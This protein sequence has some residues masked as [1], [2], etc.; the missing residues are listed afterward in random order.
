MTFTGNPYAR[1]N[2]GCAI[3]ACLFGVVTASADITTGLVGYYPL[4]GDT[5][6]HSGNGHDG[7]NTGGV[8][9]TDRLGSPS[10]AISFD[11]TGYVVVPS[12]G[13]F[14]FGQNLTFSAWV[15]PTLDNDTAGVISRPRSTDGTGFRL[16][17]ANAR[18]DFG[19]MDSSFYPV[20]VLGSEAEPLGS[21]IQLVGTIQGGN[22]GIY[23][24]GARVASYSTGLTPF[25]KGAQPLYIGSEGIVGR[26]DR[27]FRGDVDDVRIYDRALSAS[28][29]SE[30]YGQGMTEIPEPTLTTGTAAGLLLAFAIWKAKFDPTRHPALASQDG[31]CHR[32]AN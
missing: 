24:N 12:F 7:I 26:G 10:S 8:F 18:P 16:G 29:V 3:F 28:D 21:W 23:I 20:N 14:D 9:V 5:L 15:R 6:D 32:S 4:D 27:S 2:A 11:G 17:F 31:Q 30:L 19:F 13:S 25:Y 22:V 1:A